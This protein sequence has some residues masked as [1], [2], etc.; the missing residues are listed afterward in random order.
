[1]VSAYAGALQEDEVTK[2]GLAMGVIKRFRALFV[3]YSIFCSRLLKKRIWKRSFEAKK[4][5][6]D[7]NSCVQQVVAVERDG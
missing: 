5:F 2:A 6:S 7:V 4:N 1:M 3:F